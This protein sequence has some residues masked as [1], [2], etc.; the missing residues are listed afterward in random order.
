MKITRANDLLTNDP[1]ISQT[2]IEKGFNTLVDQMHQA[3][4]AEKAATFAGL[5]AEYFPGKANFAEL[6]K[7]ILASQNIHCV[8]KF[9]ERA[10][11]HYNASNCEKFVLEKGSFLEWLVFLDDVK[12]VHYKDDFTR[13]ILWDKM[14]SKS[15]ETHD[16][17]HYYN[18]LVDEIQ[19]INHAIVNQWLI[20]MAPHIAYIYAYIRDWVD[21]NGIYNSLLNYNKDIYSWNEFSKLT[22]FFKNNV[23]R[24]LNPLPIIQLTLDPQ[25]GG[26][27]SFLDDCK[28]HD[29]AIPTQQVQALLGNT[30]NEDL[31]YLISNFPGGDMAAAQAIFQ[32]FP[33]LHPFELIWNLHGFDINSFQAYMVERKSVTLILSFLED[34]EVEGKNIPLLQQVV[35][36]YGSLDDL[37]E[38]SK[39]AS[40]FNFKSFKKR[41]NDLKE[42][43]FKEYEGSDAKSGLH[44]ENVREDLIRIYATPIR[45][46]KD[47]A[48][49]IEFI[50]AICDN[51]DWFFTRRDIMS[52][53]NNNVFI[54]V[55]KMAK[56]KSF[57]NLY[58]ETFK[59]SYDA[60]VRLKACKKWTNGGEFLDLLANQFIM[61]LAKSAN[62]FD[63]YIK[64]AEKVN[65]GIELQHNIGLTSDIIQ[66]AI[67][68]PK[69]SLDDKTNQELLETFGLIIKIKDLEKKIQSLNAARAGLINTED[70]YRGFDVIKSLLAK[71]NAGENISFQRGTPEYLAVKQ[72]HVN[73][74]MINDFTQ[75]KKYLKAAKPKN[76]KLKDFNL[77]VDGFSFRVLN[78]LDPYAFKVGAE[79]DCCQRIG[80]AGETAA[81][82]SFINPE[83]SVLVLN[84]QDKL[85]AQSY[86][87]YVP[88]E[89]G[90]ILDNVEA[91]EHVLK[92]LGLDKLS[93][94]RLYADYAATLKANFPD[95]TY[96]KC[97]KGYNKLGNDLFKT[98]KM[99]EDPRHFEIEAEREEEDYGSQDE[100]GEWND[101]LETEE[102]YSDFDEHDHINLLAPSAAI[103]GLKVEVAKR[104]SERF[105]LKK[106]AYLSTTNLRTLRL[107]QYGL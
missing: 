22:S 32:S 73:L 8:T 15:A 7:Y 67:L 71:F 90:L 97:G 100:D 63:Q 21:V 57:L 10:C 95:L 42:K 55:Y 44:P 19:G 35:E 34:C 60:L 104:A 40:K 50:N 16:R 105:S 13:A 4:N 52:A 102:A 37:G 49:M 33:E 88:A 86:F 99:K 103:K 96:V 89:N 56:G 106:M 61:N 43:Q 47:N 84:Y 69:F 38:F 98:D 70:F 58:N 77:E 46:P 78:F 101:P 107:R 2:E 1:N 59:Q 81:I 28:S 6:E 24:G 11:E 31:A 91:N 85:I 41:Y 14:M 3:P 65:K 36:R 9:A 26:L 54:V 83:A 20:E 51:K 79:T 45:E 76:E 23:D 64:L 92:Y 5:I 87:H 30:H 94:S 29:V 48:D 72:M 53:L 66:R 17:N 39:H 25:R 74:T 62:N 75:I 82:D 68:N 27:S 80:G 12:V 93:L 18:K